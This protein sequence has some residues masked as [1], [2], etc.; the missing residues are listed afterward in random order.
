MT[1]ET[2]ECVNCKKAMGYL[3]YYNQKMNQRQLTHVRN[4]SFILC[5]IECS[6]EYQKKLGAGMIVRF[7]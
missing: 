1:S 7:L 5:S 6:D 3:E 2:L 4:W